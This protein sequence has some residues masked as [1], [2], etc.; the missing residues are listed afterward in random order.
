MILYYSKLRVIMPKGEQHHAVKLTE[1][2]VEEMRSLRAN[3]WK[4]KDIHRV[5]S[6]V[7]FSAVV[8]A[9]NR[10]TWRCVQ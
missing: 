6:F 5:Y 2:H 8:K 10:I 7:S 4:M 3:G 9:V 1:M